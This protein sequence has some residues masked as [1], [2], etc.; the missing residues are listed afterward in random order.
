MAETGSSAASQEPGAAPRVDIR[1]LLLVIAVSVGALVYFAWDDVRDVVKPPK[2]IAPVEPS[3]AF[4][5]ANEIKSGRCGALDVTFTKIGAAV[6]GMTWTA[7]DG[8][9]ETLI[10]QEGVANRAFVVEMPG[11]ERWA[12]HEFRLISRTDENGRA[13]FRF[14][15]RTDDGLRLAKTF[16]VHPDRPVV[17][18]IVEMTNIPPGD[19]VTQ[20]GWTLRVTNAVGNVPDLS[21]SDPLI[22]VC[23]DGITD[24]HRVRR[25]SGVQEWPTAVERKRAGR[26]QRELPPT[27]EWVCTAT[28]YFGLVVTPREPLTGDGDKPLMK[29]TRTASAAAGV[30]IQVP[31]PRT[32]C[33]FRIYAGPKQYEALRALGGRQEESVK[34]WFLGREATR[35]LKLVRDRVVPNYGLA[36]VIVTVL[37]RLLLWPVTS[38]NLRSLVDINVANAR[39]KEIDAREPSRTDRAAHDAWLKQA[40]VWED[41]QR[42]AI[43]GVYLP[44]IILLPVLLILYYALDAGYEFYRQPFTL[45]IDD[46]SK[47]DAYF[48]LPVLMGL[49]MMGQMRAMS[50]NPARERLWVLMPVGFTVL[51]A[52]FSA[53]LVLFW[54][55]D[56]LVGWLQLTII[57]RGRR[58]RARRAAEGPEEVAGA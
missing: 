10:G 17:D 21:R 14:E 16:V 19:W 36:I 38:Y 41:V 18:L 48:I 29:F 2:I 58:R 25:V 15:Q 23:S 40:R 55:T 45:W 28:R 33:A 43:I 54:L 3:D 1:R 37:F 6:T 47:R 49:A 11:R 24:H 13:V 42:R 44:M 27:L 34:Y 53:G 50:E 9:V 57:R 51:F 35:L 26:G 30:Q 22:S 12:D 39:L 8:H 7:P 52:F 20:K 4:L 56:T 32:T 46:I 5:K 31:A